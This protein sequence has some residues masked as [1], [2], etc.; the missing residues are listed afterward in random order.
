MIERLLAEV[1]A[2][3]KKYALINQ[4][5]GA[6]FNIFDMMDRTTDEVFICR[7]LHELLNPEGV[8]HQGSAYLKLFAS[9]V[10]KLD[11]DEDELKSAKV[12]KE[13]AIPGGKR[14]DL[15]ISRA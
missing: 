13:Y 4:K 1:S 9:D 12:Y 10:L 6:Y 2:I 15:E 8:H 11:F 14:I 5:T 7:F 3:D